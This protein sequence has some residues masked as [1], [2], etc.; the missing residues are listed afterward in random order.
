VFSTVYRYA[1][2]SV[3]LSDSQLHSM[4][5]GDKVVFQ[6]FQDGAGLRPS[7]ILICFMHLDYR[8]RVFGGLYHCAKLV[9]IGAL[10][11]T[12]LNILRVRLENAY[13]RHK[14]GILGI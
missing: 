1:S 14:I 5:N 6:F 9:G 8:R 3:S 13:S 10:V 12:S 4:N 11:S 7:A 2:E